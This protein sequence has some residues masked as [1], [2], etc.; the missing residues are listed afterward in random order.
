MSQ[1]VVSLIRKEADY[2]RRGAGKSAPSR[3][4][5]P[6][7]TRLFGLQRDDTQPSTIYSHDRP[8]SHKTV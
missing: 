5:A 4:E 6:N 3:T 2:P 7:G 1:D 8:N